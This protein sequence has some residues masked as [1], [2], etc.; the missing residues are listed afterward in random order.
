LNIFE[1]ET[2]Q[3]LNIIFQNKIERKKENKGNTTFLTGRIESG[4]LRIPM[5]RADLVRQGAENRS[6][7][8]S[9]PFSLHG[10]PWNARGGPLTGLAALFFFEI[11]DTIIGKQATSLKTFQSP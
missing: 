3:N 5:N 10:S 6:N 1:L 4:P 11:N 8:T 2:L 7:P 9:R